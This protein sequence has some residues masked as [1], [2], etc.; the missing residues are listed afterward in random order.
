MER[1]S[2][3]GFT[4]G[5]PW[6]AFGAEP[7][8]TNE[9]ERADPGSDLAFYRSLLS[10]RR[11]REAFATG[12]LRVLSTDDPSILLYVR[13]S[14]DETYVVAVGMDESTAR[15]GFAATASLPGDPRRL[16]GDAT[17]VRGAPARA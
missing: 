5:E 12:S 6:I 3:R 17:L 4:T 13:E 1:R 7:E 8:R 16:F 11:G 15:S 9:A 2:G 10:M 14:A